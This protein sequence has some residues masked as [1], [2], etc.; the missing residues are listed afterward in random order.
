[1][2]A[3]EQL[4]IALQTAKAQRKNGELDERG[5]YTRLLELSAQLV[6]ILTQE[7]RDTVTV[8]HDKEIKK[9]IPLILAF[10]EDQIARFRAREAQH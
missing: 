3:L 9:Q 8:M 7:V 6:P 4:A 1:M 10:L 2:E 5:F